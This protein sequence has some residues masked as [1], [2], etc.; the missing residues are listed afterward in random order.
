MLGV[1]RGVCCVCARVRVC[2]CVCGLSTLLSLSLQLGSAAAGGPFGL[3]IDSYGWH[4]AL[5]L[6]AAMALLGGVR[7]LA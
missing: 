7:G 5:W 3:L 1:C 6:L 2:A 4:G